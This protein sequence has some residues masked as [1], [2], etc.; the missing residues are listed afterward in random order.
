[1]T[2]QFGEGIIYQGKEYSMCSE[3]LNSYFIT[4]GIELNFADNCSAL[5]RGYV[6][7]W[8]VIDNRLYLRAISA[9][10][11]DGSEVTLES[12]FPG[13]P[14]RVFAHWYSGILRIPDGRLL[15]YIHMGYASEYEKDILI[16]VENGVV[17]E[18]P[19]QE[20]VKAE[21]ENASEGYGVAAAV[22]FPQKP[23]HK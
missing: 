11:N 14:D 19:I 13:F 16:E 9:S 5:W 4:A 21:N 3:P 6:G 23:P 8:E 12:L 15:N 18:T 22:V 1:M 20:N 2:A 7:S 10:L 17:I